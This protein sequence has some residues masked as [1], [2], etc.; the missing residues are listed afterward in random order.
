MPSHLKDRVHARMEKTG[1]SYEQALRHVRAQETR[2]PAIA[3]TLI[4]YARSVERARSV[5]DTAFVVAAVRAEE[6]QRPPEERLFE[7]PY[8]SHFAKAGEHL[9]ETTRRF[10]DL[11]FVRDGVRLRTR[12]IDDTL[13]EGIAAGLGQVVLLGSGFDAR[14]LRLPEIA[15]RSIPVFEVDTP[16]QLARKKPILASAGVAVPGHVSY[17]PFD[18]NAAEYARDLLPA[19][20][21]KGF[22]P[23]AG[24]L[25]VWEGV[26]GYIDDAG[27]DAS[28]AFMAAA[29][30]PGTRVAFTF[31]E[32]S[33]YPESIHDRTRRLGFRE[34]SD[35]G[36]DAVWRRYLP[37]EPPPEAAIVRLGV[38]VV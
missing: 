9:A 1:E 29:G 18:Y 3:P 26:V 38:A 32:A 24:C 20:E 14:A 4:P 8:A 19:L 11:P 16:E 10:L 27:I 5:A 13:R 37:G 17:V 23:G 12:F 31:G 15:A 33:F 30:G 34:C 28:L 6:S 25:F 35:I 22:R 7:D 36:T 2:A 21:A